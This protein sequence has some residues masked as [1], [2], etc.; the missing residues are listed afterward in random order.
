LDSTEK[1]EIPVSFF[2]DDTVVSVVKD[3]V[4]CDLSEE[5]VVLNFQDGTYYGLNEVGAC[6][7]NMIQEPKRVSDIRAALLKEFAVE[8]ADC[9]NDLQG[10]LQEL[11]ARK[12][13]TRTDSQQGR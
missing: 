10:F 13:I 3:Q 7:W 9:D 12:L 4:S 11:N 2:S 8:E 6:I 5:A 1:K